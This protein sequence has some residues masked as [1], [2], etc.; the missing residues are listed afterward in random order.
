LAG[1]SI[2]WQLISEFNLHE[3][4]KLGFLI[5]AALILLLDSVS[6]LK[7]LRA[8]VLSKS[9]K[10][11]ILITAGL[12]IISSAGW[13]ALALLLGRIDASLMLVP[14]CA[15]AVGSLA[16][17][18]LPVIYVSRVGILGATLIGSSISTG[19]T[20]LT[21]T[22]IFI[23]CSAGAALSP[24]FRAKLQQKAATAENSEI[25]VD[26]VNAFEQRQTGWFWGTDAA[27][28]LNYVSPLLS[29]RLGTQMETL[30]GTSFAALFA[31]GKT[32]EFSSSQVERTVS[33]TLSAGL[34]F[35]DL[36]VRSASG[37]E[38]WWSLSGTPIQDSHGRCIGFLGNGTDLTAQQQAEAEATKLALYDGLTGL[39]NRV[40]IRN[41]LEELLNQDGGRRPDCGLFL[42]DLDRFKNVND[43]LGHPV[44]DELLKIVAQRLTRIVGVKGQVGRL[45]GDEFKVIIPEVVGRPELAELADSIIS[46]LSLPYV[47][48]DCTVQIGATVGIAVAPTDGIDPDELTRNADL[49]LYAAK[50][51]GKGVHRFYQPEMHADADFKRSL[52]NDLREVLTE[53]QM[54][55]VYQPV[56]FAQSEEIAGFEALIRWHHPVHGPISPAIFIPI[57][58][59]VGLIGRIGDWVIR[60][61]C[62]EAV[63]WPEHLRIAVN[64]SPIQFTSPTLP[65]TLMNALAETGLAPERLE[66]EIT[67]GVFLQENAA[68][69]QTFKALTKLGVRLVL[70][71]FGTGYASLG[72]LKRVPFSKIKIDQSFVRGAESENSRNS[73]IIHAIVSLAENLGMETVAEGAETL[74]E[75]ELIRK[76]GC[77]QIQG[78]I[79]GQ[80]MSAEKAA[81]RANRA[82]SLGKDERQ[83]IDREPRVSLMR[84]ATI[85]TD[86][87]I[88]SVRIK[89][90]S[91]MGALIEASGDAAI[92]ERFS[93]N[94]SDDWQM[95]GEVRWRSGTRFGVKFDQPVDV[96]AFVKSGI[97]RVVRISEAEANQERDPI[98][99]RRQY[100]R[101]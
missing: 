98:F 6:W 43:T 73:A 14:I 2:L 42:L 33:F 26:L 36:I 39:P 4:I 83:E 41:T 90:I 87:H 101:L 48:G 68:T 66:L 75:I 13:A 69:D 23:F 7:P 86:G 54:S 80:P 85:H 97:S 74:N 31:S 8:F 16:A 1:L 62:A 94:V 40:Q 88:H 51:A 92:G 60:Q 47:I 34:E 76:L 89:N 70:D 38:Q 100:G 25:F 46:R 67:E 72:Y 5:G 52:E 61:A 29:G 95:S 99:N 64:L 91:H 19:H 18:H 11:S 22:A 77:T 15:L 57:A 12:A 81:A 56:V 55:V 53:Q 50:A 79:F 65:V 20:I 49:A 32:G 63:K 45:G 78:Y 21:S 24:I 27:G 96:D 71:D 93:L 58:E 3:N 37:G 9:P 30:I 59:E 35:N 44:G 17:F 82:P 84:F 10:T 28:R